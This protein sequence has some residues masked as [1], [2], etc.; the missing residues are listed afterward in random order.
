MRMSLQERMNY[1]FNDPFKLKYLLYICLEYTNE[2][3]LQDLFGT[4]SSWLFACR[5][6]NICYQTLADYCY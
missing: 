4:T 3:K 6:E 5:A 2:R 1:V